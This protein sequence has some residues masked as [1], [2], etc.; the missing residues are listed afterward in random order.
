MISDEEEYRGMYEP[1]SREILEQFQADGTS[2]NNVARHYGVS[3]STVSR[4]Y[5]Y[6]G[7]G[8]SGGWY[9]KKVLNY[10]QIRAAWRKRGTITG[11]AKEFGIS[12]E[13]ARREL[14]RLSQ[15]DLD[16]ADRAQLEHREE[17]CVLPEGIKVEEYREDGQYQHEWWAF[18]NDQPFHLVVEALYKVNV[19]KRKVFR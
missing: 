4:W 2:Q 9:S 16:L 3:S 7:L 19:R 11:V 10:S 15:D 14:F 6:Y 12:Q 17:E 13:R 1:P 5:N 18:L 8:R